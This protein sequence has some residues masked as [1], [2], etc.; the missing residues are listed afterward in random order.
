[1]DRLYVSRK[2]EEKRT[3]IIEDSVDASIQGFE[4]YIKKN[5]EKLIIE[6]RNMTGSIM[7]NRLTISRKQKW[8]EKQLF[9]Y[10]KQQISKERLGHR[11]GKETLS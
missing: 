11:Y 6:A 10:F 1:M 3:A 5:Q 7:I 4:I 9:E 8:G 2:K